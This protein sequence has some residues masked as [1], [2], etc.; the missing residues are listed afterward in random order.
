MLELAQKPPT[1]P[2]VCSI[3]PISMSIAAG[4]SP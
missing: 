1:E 4:S 2:S 3:D